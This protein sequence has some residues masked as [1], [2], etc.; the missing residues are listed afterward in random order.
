MTLPTGGPVLV[1]LSAA[2]GT[3]LTGLLYA[4]PDPAAARAAVLH[5][6]GKGGNFYSGPS[7]TLPPLVG[8]DR[9]VHLALNLRC[10]DLAY[11]R[12]DGPSG[13]PTGPAAADGG[14]WERLDDGAADIEAGV[15]WLA[16][17]TKLPVAVVGHSAGGYF[18]GDYSARRPDIAARVFLSPLTSVRIPLATWW[19]DEDERRRVGDTAR[20]MVASGRG[21]LLIPVTSWYYAISAGSLVE[22]LDERPHRWLDGCNASATP[23][24]LAWG[25][26]ETR[27]PEWRSIYEEI[28]V[29]GKQRLEVP[30]VG[31]QYDGAHAALADAIT[32]FIEQAGTG[33]R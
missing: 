11:S 21:H 25:G 10:H 15:R 17:R 1:E 33:S 28:T 5:V 19:P 3:P 26:A 27:I 22:R 8:P 9:F 13:S 16:Q 2:D 23:L 20:E 6:H 31:H 14:M 32:D 24:L 12:P 29:P 18:L 30:G 4:P 7:R